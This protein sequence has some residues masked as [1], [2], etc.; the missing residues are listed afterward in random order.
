[1][2][3]KT[4]FN[5]FKT[6]MSSNILPIIFIIGGIIDQMTDTFVDLLNELDAPLWLGS[7]FKI[8]VITFG[9]F[10]LFYSIPKNKR[11]ITN[12]KKLKDNDGSQ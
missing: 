6:W 5:R 9:A 12:Y 1:M 11:N 4:N 10:K 2:Q 8:I 3:K 7:L